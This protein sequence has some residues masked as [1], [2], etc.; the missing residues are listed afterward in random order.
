MEIKEIAKKIS[1]AGGRLY[2]VGGAVRDKLLKRSNYDE[3]YCVVG[4]NGLEFNKLFPEAK[5]D[6]KAFPVF[7][8][9]G[10]EFAIARKEKKIGVGHKEFEIISG[11]EITLKEDLERRDVTINAMAEDVLSGELFDYFDG[12]RDLER[13][14]IRAIG[15]HFKEDPLRVYR[16]ARFSSSLKFNVDSNTINMMHELKSELKYLSVERVFAEFEKALN[17]DKPSIFFDVLKE[18]EVL[19]VHLCQYIN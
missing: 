11:K 14:V 5:L 3:D 9:Y 17:S 1:G 4:L 10:R 12:K 19:D 8:L 13:R 15:E 6:G 16:V 18:T 7:R 2:L